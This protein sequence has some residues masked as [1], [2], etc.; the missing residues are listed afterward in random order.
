M[1]RYKKY[2]KSR[3]EKV[4]K[5]LRKIGFGIVSS[6]FNLEEIVNNHPTIS[7]KIAKKIKH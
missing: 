1:K 7:L 5:A 3:L 2:R 4:A 6:S